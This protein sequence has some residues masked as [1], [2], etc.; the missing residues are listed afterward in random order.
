MNPGDGY[1]S[2]IVNPASGSRGHELVGKKFEQY[3]IE[4]GYEVRIFLTSSLNHACELANDAA[5]DYSCAMVVVVGGDG[6][7]REVTHGLEGSDKPLL[8][9][10]CGTENLLANEL[11]FDERFKTIVD[12]FE[13]AYTRPLDLGSVNG[14]CFTSVVG[15]GFDGEIVK[16][17]HQQRIG[18]IDHFDYFWPIWRTFWSYKFPPMKITVDQEEIFEGPCM[19]FV[20]NI[21]RY[22]LG[23]QI[24]QGADYSDGLLDICIYKCLS[25]VHLIKHS[26]FT[27][28]KQHAKGKDVIYRQG[29]NITITSDLAGI[30][31]ELDGDPG[32]HLPVN[33]EIIPQAINCL[34]PK[35][36]KPAGVRARL[37][38]ILR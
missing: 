5:V 22:A 15:V 18:H 27:I 38:R 34:V 36:A 33:I 32:P 16:R 9:V 20:G 35:D 13:Q 37:L 25:Q 29:K 12:T 28:F 26:L 1:I 2:F 24:L 7:I 14:R 11:G 4:K 21:S 10:P 8:I 31:T 3:L 6:T 30:G 17:V 23:L 19:V